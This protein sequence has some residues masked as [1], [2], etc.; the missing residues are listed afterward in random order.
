M[1]CVDRLTYH[2]LRQK[3]TIQDAES[4][5]VKASELDGNYLDLLDMNAI[6]C[7]SDETIQAGHPNSMPN[8]DRELANGDPLY[9]SFVDI[10]CDDVSGNRSKSWNKH[11]NLYITHRNL[12]RTLLQ[13]QFYLHFVSTSN[14]AS[15]ADQFHAIRDIIEYVSCR[16]VYADWDSHSQ[17]RGTYTEPVKVRDAITGQQ[18]RF[19]ICVNCCPGDNPAQSDISGH[20]GSN[21][22]FPCR[23]CHVGGTQEVKATEAGFWQMFQVSDSRCTC[24]IDTN[25]FINFWQVRDTTF[26]H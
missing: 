16:L 18:T 25:Q 12:P 3:A 13:Q 14:H 19:R 6:P 7:W 24:E 4:C 8:P 10:F 11:W 22:N 15:G 26:I 2:N 20:I 21:G 5:I 23:K 17:Y 1:N 9:T